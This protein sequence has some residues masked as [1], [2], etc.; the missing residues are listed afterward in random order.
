MHPDPCVYIELFD[1]FDAEHLMIAA[2]VDAREYVKI[3]GP[4]DRQVFEKGAQMQAFDEGK[5]PNNQLQWAMRD[6]TNHACIGNL[7][8]AL[9]PEGSIEV[10]YNV[11]Q[12]QRRKGIATIALRLLLSELTS[13]LP[14]RQIVAEVILPNP[15]SCKVLA[16][17]GFMEAPAP[18]APSDVSGR[19][20]L[21]F[22]WPV[23]R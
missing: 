7:Q 1:D 11:R 22:I 23:S 19:P 14:H 16:K 6:S 12:D 18:A 4:K 3:R 8:A 10:G 5:I 21:H 20:K 15:P 13:N 2:S 9:T 17:C